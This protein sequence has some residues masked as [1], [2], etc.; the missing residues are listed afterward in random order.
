MT[1]LQSSWVL[2]KNQY[3]QFN[4]ATEETIKYLIF[5][6]FYH[7]IIKRTHMFTCSWLTHTSI[8]NCSAVPCKCSELNSKQDKCYY[9]NCLIERSDNI[10]S[11]NKYIE[12][13]CIPL[14]WFFA[15]L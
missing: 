7:K 5:F 3:M 14:H 1:L 9:G 11:N 10:Y 15:V 12:L 8:L 13:Y 6:F 2:S 4:S